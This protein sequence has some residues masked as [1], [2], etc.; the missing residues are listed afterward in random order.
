MNMLA[1]ESA[2]KGRDFSRAK[3]SQKSGLK[4]ATSVAPKT[5]SK[6]KGFKGR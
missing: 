6:I 1:H 4:G 3:I 2:L 5:A